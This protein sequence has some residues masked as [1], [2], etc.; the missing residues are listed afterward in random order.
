MQEESERELD[1]SEGRP[2]VAE[3]EDNRLNSLV[4]RSL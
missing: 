4:Q 1:S 3:E 2:E